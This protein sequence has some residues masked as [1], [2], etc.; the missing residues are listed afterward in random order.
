MAEKTPEIDRR[1]KEESGF[2]AHILE[3]LTG[4]QSRKVA[5]G[6]WVFVVTNGMKESHTDMP[7]ELWW[8]GVLLA[9]ALIGLG[10]ILDDTIAKFGD[11]IA[12]FAADK[13][14]AVFSKRIEATTEATTQTTVTTEVPHVPPAA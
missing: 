2:V 7:W 4:K 8:K 5:F 9:G 3:T 13:V 12:V 6:I 1:K 14:K 10:T 11:L